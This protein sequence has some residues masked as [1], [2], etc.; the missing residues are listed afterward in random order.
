MSRKRPV[1][2]VGVGVKS[3]VEEGSLN[4][5]T[6]VAQPAPWGRRCA[7]RA[8]EELKGDLGREQSASEAGKS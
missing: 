7:S 4:S 6:C 2:E 8:L 3:D 1:S 5:H